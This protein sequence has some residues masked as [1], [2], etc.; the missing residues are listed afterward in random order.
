VQGTHDHR[1]A[2][3]VDLSG[4]NW[5]R[6]LYGK[7]ERTRVFEGEA[8]IEFADWSGLRAFSASGVLI[9]PHTDKAKYR[10]HELKHV[11]RVGTE[12]GSE[13]V[14]RIKCWG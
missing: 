10:I 1:S 8:D 4:T 3:L 5:S 2:V 7:G 9:G 12:M 11:G 13:R 6:K 14:A